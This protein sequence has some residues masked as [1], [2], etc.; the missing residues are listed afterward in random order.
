MLKKIVILFMMF[1]ILPLC[2]TVLARNATVIDHSFNFSKAVNVYVDPNINFGINVNMNELDTGEVYKALANGQKQLKKYKLVQSES[3]ADLIIRINISDWDSRS[4]YKPKYTSI[5]YK[6]RVDYTD[7]DGNEAYT[8]IPYKEMMGGDYSYLNYFTA[9]YTVYDKMGNAVYIYMDS[10]DD[11]KKNSKM[12][13]RATKDFF[14]D[15]NKLKK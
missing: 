6:K 4:V 5:S 15:I 1:M 13:E 12:F 11:G 9:K 10:R 3:I 8:E 2:N 7:K 14:K